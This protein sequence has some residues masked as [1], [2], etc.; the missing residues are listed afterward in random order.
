MDSLDL[1]LETLPVTA[2]HDAPGASDSAQAINLRLLTWLAYAPQ[3]V[4]WL[5][6][7]ATALAFARKDTDDWHKALPG[8]CSA[9]ARV[10]ANDLANWRAATDAL[11]ASQAREHEDLL[12]LGSLPPGYPMRIAAQHQALHRQRLL[13]RF[14]QDAPS[15][16]TLQAWRV[17]QAQ[18][19]A[20]W[21]GV[22]AIALQ[23]GARW[24]AQLQPLCTHILNGMRAEGILQVEEGQL[25]QQA[26]QRLLQ[27]E[28]AD[29]VTWLAVHLGEQALPGVWIMVEQA[30]WASGRRDAPMLLWVHGE[31]GG[32]TCLND[33][34]ALLERLL[35][36]LGSGALAATAMLADEP[37][38]AGFKVVTE[39]L[40]GL[41]G[42]LVQRWQEYL[43]SESADVQESRLLLARAA[44][45]MP[46][47]TC[48]QAA[49]V[50]VE[51]EWQA[52][53]LLEQV[54]QW[55]LSRSD[56]E[57]E[58]YARQLLEYHASALALE[59][60][61][62]L[63][64]P[65]FSGW[66]GALLKA[67][68][69]QDLGIE[70]AVDEIVL[71][72][73][74]P[75]MDFKLP[76]VPSTLAEIASEGFDLDSED[77]CKRLDMAR[78]HVEGVDPDYLSRVL[79]ELDP[80]GRYAEKLRKVF[81]PA[82]AADPHRLRHPYRLQ[83]QLLA[84]SERWRRNLSEEGARLLRLAAE[85]QTREQLQD[86]GVTLHW[87]VIT[88]VEELGDSIG[89]AA[90]LVNAAGYTL[91]YLPGAP[92]SYQLIERDSLKQALESLASA[93]GSSADMAEYV[94]Q[95]CGNDPQGLLAYLN[96]AALRRYDGYLSS[97]PV[98][99]QTLVDMQLA[100]RC[101]VLIA[102]ARAIGRSQASIDKDNNW[103]DHVRHVGYLKAALGVIPGVGTWY[104]AMQI[105]DGAMQIADAWRSG[106]TS[107]LLSGT[108][109]IALGVVDILLTALPVGAGVSALR[110]VVRNV[111]RQ[112]IARQPFAGYA[113]GQPLTGAEAMTGVD[114]NTWRLNGKQYI[115]QDGLAYE[116]YRRSDEA[117]LRLR[118]TA[119][120]SYEAPVR[121][122]GA[123]WVIHADVGLRGGGGKLSEAE[124][125]LATWGPSSTEGPLAGTNRVQ[126]L[127]RGRQILGRYSFTNA[128]QELEF[129][130]SL[131]Q[132]GA[133]PA[134]ARQ[135]L[136]EGS[137][138]TSAT[139]PSN[140]WQAVRWTINPGDEVVDM[141]GGL[142]SVTFARAVARQPGV[143]L[144][145]H[146]YPVLPSDF[147]GDTVY[148]WPRG[149]IPDNLRQ[150][151]EL[152]EQGNGPVRI[153][154]GANAV[155]APTVLGGFAQTFE[156]RLATRFSSMGEGSRLAL[157]EALYRGADGS[158]AGLT[159]ARLRR[160]LERIDDPNLEPLHE[161]SVTTLH[162]ATAQMRLSFGGKYPQLSSR[163]GG[164]PFDQLVWNLDA[165][166]HAALRQFVD[167]LHAGPV[168]MV[169][170]KILTARG[171][172]VLHISGVAERHL[173][174]FTRS[175][176]RHVYILLQHRSLGQFS[177]Q[178]SNGL[179]LLSDTWLDELIATARD[180]KMAAALRSARQQGVLHP[181]LG[182]LL[183]E[184]PDRTALVWQRVTMAAT[185]EAQLPMLRNWRHQLRPLAA[186]DREL[187]QGSG[188][189][190]AQGQA[191]VLGVTVE[192]RL[193][194]VFATGSDSR[195]LL[196]RSAE[197][198]TPLGFDDLE[199]CVR[200]R[201]GEQ[202]WMIISGRGGWSVRRPLFP[203]PLSLQVRRARSGLTRQ[204][205]L[206]AA[207]HLFERAQGSDHARLLMLEQVTA[208]W[209]HG[210]I[211]VDE[212]A[213]PLLLLA[214]QRP[215][216]LAGGGAWRLALPLDSDSATPM[217]YYLRASGGHSQTLLAM[218]SGSPRR[219][220]A[221]SVIDVLLTRYGLTLQHRAGHIAQYHQLASNRVYLVVMGVS[222]QASVEFALEQGRAVLSQ[223]WM[224]HWRRALPNAALQSLQQAEGGGRL[225]R[226][227]AVLRLEEGPHVGQIALQRLADF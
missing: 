19:Q 122:D 113:A 2:E 198:S 150:L 192:G 33:R 13:A 60:W 28:A 112:R 23:P 187:V 40:N 154:L 180:L 45:A 66:A 89:G 86:A 119:T 118:A 21:R 123:R 16:A 177:L 25:A 222:E 132:D 176:Q 41:V 27:P 22:N 224:E 148:V 36:T 225:V 80:L 152:I 39:G 49:L 130:H 30:A 78:W 168:G 77:E 114:L 194:P 144:Q 20:A 83:L 207:R 140:D 9:D 175:G 104:S 108:L 141:R 200:E 191:S 8:E 121:Q 220:H 215:T 95:R 52:D 62:D 88:A 1:L 125:L 54:P 51:R 69:Q 6:Q 14:G 193:L 128:N 208:S 34:Q 107:G 56:D 29:Q 213:D 158:A 167:S 134:W 169:L 203:M 46:A 217:V 42:T 47:D 72:R 219:Q 4:V 135:Y 65:T 202:P 190:G 98:L 96:Q 59:T 43:D 32:M 146:Y 48:R 209:V 18:R 183:L 50:Q 81:D 117:T 139:L 67:R 99:S 196:S 186:T 151:D 15:M 68:I 92:S 44:L 37:L 156:Q 166:E 31:G 182:G 73:P 91:I 120:R 173:L 75:S 223:G 109:S 79:V 53:A 76:Y 61:L 160:L 110:R 126:A 124:Q 172:N 90:A 11:L 226:L 38:E 71:W 185:A 136:R 181:L 100:D 82:I 163:L 214:A 155:E 199:R 142:V 143:R 115:W 133:P 162:K 147:I 84:T 7:L 17:A 97:Q 70:L 63:Q 179:V 74:D 105:H 221:L 85:A 189:Y 35:F 26:C 5:N 102:T 111:V 103:Q 195:I 170:H 129:T 93:V 216:G 197:L 24:S 106:G 101:Y 218:V 116:V 159:Q 127:T 153:S 184:G 171:Y 174:L 188:L 145:G 149:R 201:F 131:L 178:G 55:V 165:A 210:T 137:G 212:L 138:S 12:A 87:L 227:A 211:A 205:A 204:S 64:A 157:G 94:A 206:N 58:A 57:R 3:P 164:T 161:M 10:I